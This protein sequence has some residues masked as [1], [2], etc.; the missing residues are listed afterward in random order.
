[1]HNYPRQYRYLY[2][3]FAVLGSLISHIPLTGGVF[4]SW[5]WALDLEVV[6]F[7]EYGIVIGVITGSI[8]GILIGRQS[9][10]ESSRE[11]AW[12]LQPKFWSLAIALIALAFI[13]KGLREFIF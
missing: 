6:N 12:R 2:L 4:S 1:M 11:I 9:T 3:V 10:R 7:L 8:F 13:I 5:A